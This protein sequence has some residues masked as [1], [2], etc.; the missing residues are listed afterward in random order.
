[1]LIKRT[2]KRNT[3][4][5]MTNTKN[6]KSRKSTS[7]PNR[8]GKLINNN[9]TL[10]TN[11]LKD[12]WSRYNENLWSKTR[13][14]SWHLNC[15]LLVLVSPPQHL[16]PTA[17]SPYPSSGPQTKSN[18]KYTPTVDMVWE[19]NNTSQI[20][21]INS[22]LTIGSRIIMTSL[23]PLYKGKKSTSCPQCL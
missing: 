13:N 10:E 8:R 14:L 19:G 11:S 7:S 17:N 9:S 1:M 16:Q 6:K 22:S 5:I 20:F 2:R 18:P 23:R 4:R 21:N 15:T 12:K 3:K